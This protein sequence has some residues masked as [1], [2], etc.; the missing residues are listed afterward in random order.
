MRIAKVESFAL[1]ANLPVP[2]KISTLTFNQAYA[3]LVKITTDDG[4]T[5]IGESM[6]RVAPAVTKSIIDEVLSPI[7][8]G[9]D[10]L[11]IEALWQDMFRVMRTRGHNRGFWLE[12]IGGVDI[13]LW[14]LMGKRL[15]QPVHRLLGGMSREKIEA[16]G[17]SIF[18]KPAREIE[19]DV[20]DFLAKGFKAIKV[21]IG[22]GVQKD[23]ETVR[24]V[25]QLVGPEVK[26]MVDANGA[27]DARTAIM[28][29][30]KLETLD[31]WWFEEPVPADDL[32]GYV[33][34][35]RSVNM[36]VAGGEAEFTVYGFRDLMAKEV[37]DIVQP[38]IARVGGFTGCRKIVALAEAYNLPYAPHT[39]V[40]SA[41]TLAATI[42]MAAAAPNFLIYEEMV[43][44]NPMLRI[45][46]EPL[47]S[48][49]NGYISVPSGPGLGIEVDWEQALAYHK[50]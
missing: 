8:L 35:S 49:R 23:W 2:L 27:Y 45:L 20:R 37:L 34:F 32:P 43:I 15:G 26:L 46:K 31:I 1:A 11:A 13:A 4:L 48:V 18:I 6:V 50:A 36:A 44:D 10:P 29:A 3:L 12:A 16:Y 30:K 24:L 14:D 25:R 22:S 33:K 42:Q 5:G 9:R 17:S 39:G 40:S 7:L 47:P 41:V 19:N 21:K 28:L 38:D